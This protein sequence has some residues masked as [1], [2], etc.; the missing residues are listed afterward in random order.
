MKKLLLF[1]LV[2]LFLGPSLSQTTRVTTQ[3]GFWSNPSTWDTGVPQSG[4]N[5]V[6]N[7]TLEVDVK[8]TVTNILINDVTTLY[9][10]LFIKGILNVEANLTNGVVYFINNEVD[11]GRLGQTSSGELLSEVVWQKWLERCDGWA[12]YGGPFEVAISEYG[13]FHTGVPGSSFPSFWTNTY[14]YDETTPDVDRE[15]GW[16]VPSSVNDI[17]PRGQAIYFFDSSTTTLTE[18]SVIGLNGFCDLTEIFNFRPN[19]TGANFSNENGWN[20]FSN[21]YLGA[22]NWDNLGWFKKSIEDGIWVLDNC[23]NLYSSYVNG[24]GVNGGSPLIAPGQGF[25]VKGVKNNPRLES[26]RRV[27]VDDLV[28]IKSTNQNQIVRLCL[29][30][31]EIALVLNPNATPLNDTLYD[32]SKFFTSNSTIYSEL[33]EMYSI[34]AFDSIGGVPIWVKGEGTLEINLAEYDT[35]V[36]LILEDI[37]TGDLIPLTTSTDYYFMNTFIGFT[38]RFNILFSSIT[39][40]NEMEYQQE[41]EVEGVD[42]LGRKV[43]KEYK[44]IKIKINH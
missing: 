24:V 10:T 30:D 29:N 19:Y 38:H 23:T 7:H 4:D 6:V 8:D 14:L 40:I 36:N 13:F 43:T 1:L 5:I 16:T 25:W 37:I 17:L 15:I 18:K 21:P 44:G 22:I 9:D 41:I 26:D 3:S 33:D 28:E 11:K 20:F 31:D 42:I 12:M 2:V 35:T 32:A 34:N 39:S 27:I